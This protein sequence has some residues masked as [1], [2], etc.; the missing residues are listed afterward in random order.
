VGN[1]I[2]IDFHIEIRSEDDFKQAHLMTE[3]MIQAIQIRYSN[4]DITVHY[5]PEGEM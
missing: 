5:D 1:Q 4:A 2:F 3:S